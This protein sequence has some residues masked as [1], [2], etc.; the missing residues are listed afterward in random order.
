MG[1]GEVTIEKYDPT[2]SRRTTRAALAPTTP[3]L[4]SDNVAL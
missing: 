1:L 3:S 2:V 4:A